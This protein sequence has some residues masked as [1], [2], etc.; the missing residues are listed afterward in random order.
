MRM[1]EAGFSYVH[2][3]TAMVFRSMAKI[4]LHDAIDYENAVRY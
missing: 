2:D 4:P 3:M 1:S